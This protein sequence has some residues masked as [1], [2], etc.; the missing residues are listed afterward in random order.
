MNRFKLVLIVVGLIFSVQTFAQTKVGVRVG[1]NVCNMKFDIDSDYR[2]KPE[3]KANMGFQIGII[4]DVP[5]VE[6]TLSLQPALL[7]SNKGYNLD[8]KETLEGELD[9]IDL[10]L[11]VDDYEGYYSCNY[12]YIELP[13]NLIY[14]K[15][16]FQVSAGSYFALGIGGEVKY[17][18]SY[19]VRYSYVSEEGSYE[20]EPVF[21]EVDEDTYENHSNDEDLAE[22]YRAFD[23]GL[24]FGVG[25][26]VGSVV[27]NVGY[28]P[29]L[30]NLT[31]N[32]DV[33]DHF[34][35]DYSKEV[36]QKNRVF[37]FSA[38]CFFD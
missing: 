10:N 7:F 37:T 30:G 9:A 3:A 11:Y 38:S 36:I 32:Y 2:W 5:L 4:A 28:S 16:G 21:G 27:F 19:R 20:L 13:V 25:Y 12:N 8:F 35:E 1:R 17:D 34:D 29:G 24:N 15:S 23:F 22:L 33:D 18:H 14:K 31:P 6:E 26:Q